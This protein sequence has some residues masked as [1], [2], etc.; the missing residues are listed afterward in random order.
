MHITGGEIK[1]AHGIFLIMI[2]GVQ[3][4][5]LPA[6]LIYYRTIEIDNY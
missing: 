6:A 3:W 5:Q 1:T 2:M 4:L